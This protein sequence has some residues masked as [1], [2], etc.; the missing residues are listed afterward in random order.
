MVPDQDVSHESGENRGDLLERDSRRQGA[1]SGDRA[2]RLSHR[3]SAS[4]SHMQATEGE[5]K[6]KHTLCLGSSYVLG[7]KK[8]KFKIYDQF[9]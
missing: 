4:T 9:R 8:N 3:C 5:K 6:M 1:G 7:A 2:L